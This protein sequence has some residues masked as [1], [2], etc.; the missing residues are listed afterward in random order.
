MSDNGH[1][2]VGYIGEGRGRGRERE[3]EGEKVKCKVQ[4]LLCDKRV[5]SAQ[6]ISTKELNQKLVA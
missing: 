6:F 3:E 4:L 2:I 1:K 5:S